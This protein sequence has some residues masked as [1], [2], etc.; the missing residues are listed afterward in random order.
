MEQG[1]WRSKFNEPL[2]NE[3]LGL[4]RIVLGSLCFLQC[5]W[6]LPQAPALFGKYGFL[7]ADLMKFISGWSLPLVAPLIEARGIDYNVVIY[8][9]LG[10]Q[11]IS[12]LLFTCG[13]WYRTSSIV[14]WL[15]HVFI[16]NSGELSVYGANRYLHLFS[17]M[18]IF[19]PLNNSL[20]FGTVKDLKVNPTLG[21]WALRLALALTYLN[22]G[23]AKSKGIDWWTGDAVWRA[24]NLPEF[25]QFEV[26][27][28][29][30][31][32]WIFKVAAWATLFFECGYLL[33][34][35]SRRLRFFWILIIIGMHVG[36]SVGLGLHF[37]ALSMILFNLSLFLWHDFVY[38]QR[39]RSTHG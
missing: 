1:W 30:A 8:G 29:G 18:A 11:L 32:P 13:L 35:L 28:L 22:A 19:L 9:V 3:S 20:T 36:I 6:V 4:F 2:A 31:Y 15:T 12:A 5:L 25:K 10:L 26:F 7:E 34:I 27:W 24:I 39:K 16:M 14:L 38:F 17:F 33:A 23:Y 37:F 21:L